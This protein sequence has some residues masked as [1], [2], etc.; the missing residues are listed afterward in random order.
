MKQCSSCSTEEGSDK[1]PPGSML[2]TRARSVATVSSCTVDTLTPASVSITSL[3]SDLANGSRPVLAC[4]ALAR[5]PGKRLMS[6]AAV[7]HTQAHSDGYA[8][9][10]RPSTELSA[11]RA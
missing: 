1:T 9:C 10:S 2:S 6:S 11:A 8:C 3:M 4:G 7:A 5:P